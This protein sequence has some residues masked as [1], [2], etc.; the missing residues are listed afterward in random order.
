M[1]DFHTYIFAREKCS[2]RSEMD[3]GF[4]TTNVCTLFTHSDG[5]RR[6]KETMSPSLPFFFNM[7]A[8]PRA[9][10]TELINKIINH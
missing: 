9:A 8:S 3:F 7:G 10:V 2:E 6:Q 4:Q 5:G 1:S